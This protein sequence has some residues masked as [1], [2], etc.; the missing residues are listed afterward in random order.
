LGE[1]KSLAG[2]GE[3][4]REIEMVECVRPDLTSFDERKRDANDDDLMNDAE[5]DNELVIILF[6][7][8]I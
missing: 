8:L 6:L 2:T 1:E 3:M 7:F 4:K 5:V